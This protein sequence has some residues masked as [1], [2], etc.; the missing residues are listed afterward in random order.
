MY[1]TFTRLK[2]KAVKYEQLMEA[3]LWSHIL[4]EATVKLEKV[5]F[6]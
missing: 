3:I 4:P 6:P 5:S 1:A 2:T